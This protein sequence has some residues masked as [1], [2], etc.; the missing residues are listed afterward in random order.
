VEKWR[1][2]KCIMKKYGIE[3]KNGKIFANVDFFL[4]ICTFFVRP[5]KCGA[6]CECGTHGTDG[7]IKS[8]KTTQKHK[9]A[10]DPIKKN[11]IG[12]T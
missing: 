1:F 8:I 7:K 12:I 2:V 11:N 10:Q 6:K 5:A 9:K 4:Y 3:E